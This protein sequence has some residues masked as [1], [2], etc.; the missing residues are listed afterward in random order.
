MMIKRV[1][2]KAARRKQ[3]AT[4]IVM[5]VAHFEQPPHQ[6]SSLGGG[7]C[8]RILG[9]ALISPRG[10]CVGYCRNWERRCAGLA[11]RCDG[12]GLRRRRCENRWSAPG[13]GLLM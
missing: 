12:R 6:L 11:R 10:I 9:Y 7:T 1:K 5:R 13:R 8:F 3:R 2:L 4:L